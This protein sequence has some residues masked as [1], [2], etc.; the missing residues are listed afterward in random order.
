MSAKRKHELQNGDKIAV[1][2]KL[3]KETH[4]A[5]K[6]YTDDL[7]FESV[8]KALQGII[9]DSISYYI[10]KRKQANNGPKIAGMEKIPEQL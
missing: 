1:A 9:T 5:L 7:G 6:E 10:N 3:D 4:D 8:S 2:T